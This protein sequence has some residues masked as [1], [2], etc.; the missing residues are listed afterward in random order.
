MGKKDVLFIISQP[1]GFC[2]CV[3]CRET[4]IKFTPSADYNIFRNKSQTK[5]SHVALLLNHLWSVKMS[6][7]FATEDYYILDY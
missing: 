2:L 1:H 6:Y 3:F 4:I 7:Y 5:L